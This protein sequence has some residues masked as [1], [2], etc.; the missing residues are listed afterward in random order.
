MTAALLSS[1]FCA[2]LL[3][4]PAGFPCEAQSMGAWRPRPVSSCHSGVKTPGK[5][6]TDLADLQNLPRGQAA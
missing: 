3:F 6:L 2:S 4:A 5:I 1:H